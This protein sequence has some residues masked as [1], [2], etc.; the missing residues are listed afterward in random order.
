MCL[1]K[2]SKFLVLSILSLSLLTACDNSDSSWSYSN[3][4]DSLNYQYYPNSIWYGMSQHFQL[5]HEVRRPQVKAQI[6]W[7]Q[8]HQHALYNT[9]QSA[10]PYIYYIYQQTRVRGLPAEL[11]LL[12]VIESRFD[13][14]AYSKAGASGLWQLMPHTAHNLG[15]KVNRAYDGRRDIVA[16]TNAA[17]DY[18][19]TLHTMFNSSANSWELAIGAYDAGSGT[20]QEAVK[21]SGSLDFWNL[22][23]PNETEGYLPK[24]LALAAII[25]NPARYHIQLPPIT[26]APYL[27]A[28]KVSSNTNITKVARSSG[29]SL[30]TLHNLNPGYTE[31]AKATNQTHTLLIPVSK[32][33][34]FQANVGKSDNQNLM[35]VHS[36]SP[37]VLADAG[38][39]N[40]QYYVVQAGDTLTSIAHNQGITIAKLRSLNNLDD[41][42]LHPKQ[43]L[44]LLNKPIEFADNTSADK[45]YIVQTDDTLSHIAA[46]FHTTATNI[47]ETNDLKTNIIKPGD[48]LKITAEVEADNAINTADD[49]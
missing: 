21:R 17:L 23:L 15:I 34:D 19:N 13:P 24:L 35:P 9:L 6:L 36:T 33:A 20:V 8:Q 14:Y 12:P 5:N 41:N 43:T 40:K 7:M 27:A 37:A 31:L 29:I 26:N 10:A 2:I 49:S 30:A 11:A 16:S 25:Q 32:V 45:K 18:L 46:R 4:N 1:Q 39:S 44:R 42:T 22:Q 48:V 47:K 38:T 3:G 28:V